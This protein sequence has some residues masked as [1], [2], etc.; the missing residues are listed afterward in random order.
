MALK[1]IYTFKKKKLDPD[2]E[3]VQLTDPVRAEGPVE[4]WLLAFELGMRTTLYN[5]TNYA[6]T[7]NASVSCYII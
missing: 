4:T 1:Y 6:I 5:N 2:G 3:Y 7:S